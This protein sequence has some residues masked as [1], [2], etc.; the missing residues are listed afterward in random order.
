MKEPLTYFFGVE[1][2]IHQLKMDNPSHWHN[3]KSV[4]TCSEAYLIKFIINEKIYG[5]LYYSTFT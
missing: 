5:I 2:A 1:T 4:I 3:E